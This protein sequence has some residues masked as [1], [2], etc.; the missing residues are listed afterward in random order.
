MVAA[1][2]EVVGDA[3]GVEACCLLD[4]GLC[5]DVSFRENGAVLIL[6]GAP[7]ARVA[8][9][10]APCGAIV[11]GSAGPPGFPADTVER[12]ASSGRRGGGPADVRGVSL[13]P[14]AVPRLVRRAWR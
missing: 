5:H 14:P 7:V 6:T 2:S 9:T 8:W 13:M 4:L 12:R 3:D 10:A 1:E 11:T